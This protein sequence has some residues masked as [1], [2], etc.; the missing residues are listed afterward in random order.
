MLFDKIDSECDFDLPEDMIEADFQN[1]WKD[2]STKIA[3]GS[4]KKS[5]E[6]SKQ[7]VRDIAKRRVKLGLILADVAKKNAITV[8]A[9]DME[10]AK[11]LR[12]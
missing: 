8:T 3:N 10:N 5:E 9:E 4:I 11:P 2:V 6:E 12:K 1:M 7:E